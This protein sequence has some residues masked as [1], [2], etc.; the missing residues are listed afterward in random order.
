MVQCKSFHL[1]ID[2]LVQVI[3]LV[4][5]K[6]FLYIFWQ[7]STSFFFGMLCCMPFHFNDIVGTICPSCT[8]NIVESTKALFVSIGLAPFRADWF[9][10]VLNPVHAK[11]GVRLRNGSGQI[12]VASFWIRPFLYQK[13]RIYSTPLEVRNR[14]NRIKWIPWNWNCSW[15]YSNLTQK[16]KALG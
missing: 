1:F 15:G 7:V 5:L 16:N 9:R 4:Y 13:S 6:I 11:I 14:N 8:L 12:D 10:L 3:Y 2:K